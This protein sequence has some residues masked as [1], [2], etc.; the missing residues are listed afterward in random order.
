MISPFRTAVPFG[1][2]T[3]QNVSY[4]VYSSADLTG[5]SGLAL[6]VPISLPVQEYYSCC[7]WYGYAWGVVAQKL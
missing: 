3:P 2:R 5:L 1:R 4:L 6:Y 7:V